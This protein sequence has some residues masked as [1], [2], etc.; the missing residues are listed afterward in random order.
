MQRYPVKSPPDS[1]RSSVAL[2]LKMEES[3]ASEK[4]RRYKKREKEKEHGNTVEDTLCGTD[5]RRCGE[6][7]WDTGSTRYGTAAGERSERPGIGIGSE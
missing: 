7:I 2:R 5:I 1:K 4:D 3:W 6:T